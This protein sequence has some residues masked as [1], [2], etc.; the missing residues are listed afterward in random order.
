M[1]LVKDDSANVKIFKSREFL[2][3]SVSVRFRVEQSVVDNDDVAFLNV[4]YRLSCKPSSI[5]L[6]EDF[7]PSRTVRDEL[8]ELALPLLL[9]VRRTIYQRRFDLVAHVVTAVS[10]LR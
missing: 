9:E 2:A 1:K 5:A 3:F 10:D 7:E 8:V 4:F 6:V